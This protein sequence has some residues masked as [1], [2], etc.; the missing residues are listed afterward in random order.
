MISSWLLEVRVRLGYV[1]L[2]FTEWWPSPGEA[3]RFFDADA[4]VPKR[5]TPRGNILYFVRARAR[6]RVSV[7]ERRSSEFYDELIFFTTAENYSATPITGLNNRLNKGGDLS[8]TSQSQF[9]FLLHFGAF[10]V[11]NKSIE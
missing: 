7:L 10:D 3:P 11:Y 9:D 2:G 4:K 6:A 1:R 5:A 8:T